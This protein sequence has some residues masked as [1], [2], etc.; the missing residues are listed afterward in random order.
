MTAEVLFDCMYSLTLLLEI[1]S[2]IISSEMCVSA[3]SSDQQLMMRERQA[4]LHVPDIRLTRCTR[5]LILP[6]NVH[7]Y[8][9]RL[10]WS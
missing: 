1:C 2:R 7:R 6:E 5:D 8:T 4:L 10:L 3:A 9:A